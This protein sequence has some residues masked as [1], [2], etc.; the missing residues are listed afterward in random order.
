MIAERPLTEQP[1]SEEVPCVAVPRATLEELRRLLLVY[2]RPRIECA[3][4]MVERLLERDPP[5]AL[6]PL[7][8]P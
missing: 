2:D 5:S 4:R 8:N 6:R 1:A 7:E 3:W